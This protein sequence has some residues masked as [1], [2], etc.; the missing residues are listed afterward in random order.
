VNVKEG[1]G[2]RDVEFRVSKIRAKALEHVRAPAISRA[3]MTSK[4]TKIQRTAQKLTKRWETQ[5]LFM[6]KLIRRVLYTT[7]CTCL[8]AM[9]ITRPSSAMLCNQSRVSHKLRNLQLRFHA[10]VFIRTI[11][12]RF[13]RTSFLVQLDFAVTFSFTEEDDLDSQVVSISSGI[14]RWQCE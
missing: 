6:D 3:R 5:G 14:G 13:R 1:R 8:Y 12:S 7:I 2:R 4:P 10:V 9:Q 11:A